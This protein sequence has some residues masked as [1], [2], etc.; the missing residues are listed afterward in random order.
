[1]NAAEAAHMLSAGLPVR[2]VDQY[3][4]NA[5]AGANRWPAKF[6]GDEVG[7]HVPRYTHDLN[8]A[9]SA[10]MRMVPYASY[11]LTYDHD[12]NMH[13]FTILGQTGEAA[14]ASVAVCQGLLLH[15]HQRSQPSQ[16]REA[17]RQAIGRATRGLDVRPGAINYLPSI[18]GPQELGPMKTE[19][20]LAQ[21]Q[22]RAGFD[23]STNP[24][25]DTLVIQS[26]PRG[27]DAEVSREAAEL[28]L[29]LKD[30]LYLTKESPDDDWCSAIMAA[31]TAPRT[32]T[33]ELPEIKRAVAIM[34][35]EKP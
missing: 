6:T 13:R 25:N 14:L 4:H 22:Q 2:A 23:I 10:V 11:R 9:F 35:G 18:D 29:A 17:Y 30:R 16:V 31:G 19:T 34:R 28:A 32:V 15:M 8:E 21:A 27:Y 3:I 33:H 20:V 5:R 24:A 7:E 26:N 1:M 12:R